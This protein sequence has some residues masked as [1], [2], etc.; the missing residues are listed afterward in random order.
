MVVRIQFMTNMR[1]FMIQIFFVVDFQYSEYVTD[2]KYYFS[3]K[4]ESFFKLINKE[5][6][7]FVRAEKIR[8][9]GQVFINVDP[10]CLLFD[11]LSPNQEV[12]LTH[13][14]SVVED[15]VADDFKIIANSQLLIAGTLYF[16]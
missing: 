3:Q 15:V 10:N 16:N 5:F 7:G 13:G 8:E 11:G 4:F 6:G 14:D 2:F 9:D 1:Q 12:L